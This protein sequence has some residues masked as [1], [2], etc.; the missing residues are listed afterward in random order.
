MLPQGRSED[1]RLDFRAVASFTDSFQ[2]WSLKVQGAPVG[3]ILDL[4]PRICIYEI[5]IFVYA[6]GCDAMGKV[7]IAPGK[8]KRVKISR[9]SLVS[10]SRM[11]NRMILW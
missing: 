11:F 9:W 10:P 7:P 6:W 1:S 4:S 8:F 3:Q 5:Y 2:Q